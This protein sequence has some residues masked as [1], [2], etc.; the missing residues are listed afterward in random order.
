MNC[1]QLCGRRVFGSL[2][3]ASQQV[4]EPSDTLP[5]LL[6]GVRISRAQTLPCGLVQR[7]RSSGDEAN[8]IFYG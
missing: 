6:G 7:R 2:R 3:K 8:Y 4:L 1:C 5:E